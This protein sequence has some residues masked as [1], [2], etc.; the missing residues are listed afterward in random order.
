MNFV[1]GPRKNF[2]QSALARRSLV[3]EPAPHRSQ[4]DFREGRYQG[5]GRPY[6]SATEPLFIRLNNLAAAERLCNGSSRLFI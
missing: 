6:L 2:T 1:I 5:S 4:A 3:V